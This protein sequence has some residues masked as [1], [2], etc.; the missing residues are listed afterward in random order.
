MVPALPAL[1]LS[2]LILLTFQTPKAWDATFT[3]P[4]AWEASRLRG[5]LLKLDCS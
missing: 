1:R 3:K 2:L 5:D 4:F